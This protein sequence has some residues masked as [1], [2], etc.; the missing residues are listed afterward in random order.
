MIIYVTILK[1][2][3]FTDEKSFLI[4]I[5]RII[6]RREFVAQLDKAIHVTIG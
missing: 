4:S 5:Q 1:L 3:K 6:Y 2:E